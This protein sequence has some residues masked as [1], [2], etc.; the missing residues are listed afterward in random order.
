MGLPLPGTDGVAIEVI[1]LEPLFG[2][3]AEP[4]AFKTE[5]E[6]SLLG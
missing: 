6:D 1:V 2:L 5:P 3:E 4:E